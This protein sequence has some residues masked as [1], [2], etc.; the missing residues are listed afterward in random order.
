MSNSKTDHKT[1]SE[2]DN[3]ED[4]AKKLFAIPK[5]KIQSGIK[6]VNFEEIIKP[7]LPSDSPSPEA[8]P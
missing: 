5:S 3:F 7:H 1:T 8:C 2:F 6:E 4:L